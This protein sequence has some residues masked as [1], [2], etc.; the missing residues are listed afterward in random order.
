VTFTSSITLYAQWT[1]T[2]TS[3][4]FGAVGVFSKNSTNLTKSL[5]RQVNDLAHTIKVKRYTQVALYG[6]SA[7]TGLATLDSS[8]S[9]AR[10]DSV[11]AYLRRELRTLHVEGVSIS[12]SGEGAVSDS[13]SSLYSRVEVFVS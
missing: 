4:L 7:Q 10:A 11:A 13:T 6:Y 12:A 2:P 5:I 1:S 8:L 3:T 9:R